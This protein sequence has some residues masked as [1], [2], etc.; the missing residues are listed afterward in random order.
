MRR[1]SLLGTCL[2]FLG[3]VARTALKTPAGQS[4]RTRAEHR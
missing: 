2:W 4:N 1:L 3:K